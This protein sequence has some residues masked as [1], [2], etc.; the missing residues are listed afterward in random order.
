[1]AKTPLLVT[2]GCALLLGG[3]TASSQTNSSPANGGR[4][5]DTACI[6][7]IESYVA[8]TRGWDKNDYEILEEGSDL[9]GRGFSVRHASDNGPRPRGGGGKSFHLEVD[10]ECRKVVTELGYQ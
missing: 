1:V 2:I 8:K 5:E 3:G 6:R 4:S 7:L 9:G 10:R